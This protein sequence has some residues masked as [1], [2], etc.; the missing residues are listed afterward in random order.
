MNDS[1]K[2][3]VLEPERPQEEVA[4]THSIASRLSGLVPLLCCIALLAAL[5]WPMFAGRVYVA[6]D[7]GAFHLPLRNFYSQQ[8]GAGEPFDWDPEMFG[9][10][11]L[12]GEGQAGTYH[13]LH[14]LL[15]RFLP[16]QTAFDLECL[17]SYPVMLAGMYVFLLRWRICRRGRNVRRDGVHFRRF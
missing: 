3:A 12:T 14:L 7:L 9:G 2:T 6:D 11:Y 10:F 8:L 15:Y 5:A 13:P 1:S 17:L 4:Q 16:L